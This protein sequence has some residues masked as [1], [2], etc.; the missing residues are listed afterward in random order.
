MATVHDARK[1]RSAS[2]ATGT[3]ARLERRNHVV[4]IAF[5]AQA[6]AEIYRRNFL[7][8]PTQRHTVLRNATVAS[9]SFA[10]AGSDAEDGVPGRSSG[11]LTCIA[12][13][14]SLNWF[15]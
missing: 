8:K 13:T 12:A 5:Q 11:Y 6:A 15:W 1:S 10:D 9:V 4:A 3:L 7:P 2:D 14:N